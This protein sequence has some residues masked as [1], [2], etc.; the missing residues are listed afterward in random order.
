MPVQ[1]KPGFFEE[2]ENG[3]RPIREGYQPTELAPAPKPPQGGSAVTP[4]NAPSEPVH[5]TSTSAALS[6]STGRKTGFAPA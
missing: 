6:D 4:V 1:D 3:Y 2:I 5:T